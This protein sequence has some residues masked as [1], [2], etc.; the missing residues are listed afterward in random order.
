MPTKLFE[1]CYTKEQDQFLLS[2]KDTNLK[3]REITDLFNE[4]F[5]LNKHHKTITSHC[6]YLGYSMRLNTRN[7]YTKEQDLW[8]KENQYGISR[9]ELTKQ[10]N[11][12]FGTNKTKDQVRH[13]CQFLGF[14]NG[15]SGKFDRNNIPWQKGI[16]KEEF[17]KHYS[18]ES[19]QILINNITPKR[20]HNVGDII[21]KHG[22]YYIVISVEENVVESKRIMPLARYI[23]E[24]QYGKQSG[25]YVYLFADGNYKNTDISNIVKIDRSDNMVINLSGVKGNKECTNAMID[26]LKVKKELKKL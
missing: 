9:E 7:L 24:Q 3:Y 25:D 21:N 18:K 19:L 22:I 14:K 20:I 15:Q 26:Y 17:K 23:Y 16:S 6:K 10:F 4:K 1:T 2:L 8:L 11:D 5:G 13:H 12:K